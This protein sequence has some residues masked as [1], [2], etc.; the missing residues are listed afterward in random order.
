MRVTRCVQTW[1]RL[2]LHEPNKNCDQ[3]LNITKIENNQYFT[4]Y[5]RLKTTTGGLGVRTIEATCLSAD[6]CFSEPK[7][8]NNPILIQSRQMTFNAIFNMIDEQDYFM[9]DTREKQYYRSHHTSSDSQAYEKRFCCGFL[10]R[11]HLTV[12]NHRALSLSR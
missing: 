10:R 11:S 3:S 2:F 5:G 4:S 8:Y 6:C 9:E 7:H 12:F 1:L